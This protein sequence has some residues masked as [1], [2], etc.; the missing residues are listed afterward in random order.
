MW[1]HEPADADGAL[2]C[3]AEGLRLARAVSDVGG[4]NMNTLGLAFTHL[5][6]RT[7]EA[8]IACRTA[9]LRFQESGSPRGVPLL[10][11]AIAGWFLDRDAIEPAAVISG[12]LETPQT[13]T[14]DR[15]HQE[16]AERLRTLR[17]QPG[18]TELLARGAALSYDEA[19]AY[20]L[21]Y[22]TCVES[23]S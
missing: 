21:A 8:P 20:T 23:G 9:L 3:Y 15:N 17:A 14:V 5:H 16:V 10:L 13:T 2:R 12:F 19:V 18:G 7:P 11:D 6:L 1:T 4:E 22:L